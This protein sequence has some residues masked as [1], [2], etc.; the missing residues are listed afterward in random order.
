MGGGAETQVHAATGKVVATNRSVFKLV[1][2]TVTIVTVL[3]I[4]AVVY[5]S[6]QDPQDA[7][8]QSAT[9]FASSIAKIG[10]GA[11]VGLLGGKL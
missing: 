1:F 7:A 5:L 8:I 6:V 10:F 3:C 2:L 11:I 4:A 9:T